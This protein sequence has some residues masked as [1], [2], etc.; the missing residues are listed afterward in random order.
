MAAIGVLI[1]L[2]ERERSGEGQL[3]DCS[4]FD[5][6]LSWLALVAA[7]TLA[8]RPRARRGELRLA[9]GLVCYRPYRVRRRVRH[10]GRAR[11]E[12]LGARS[13][14][15][16]GREDLIDHAFDPPGSDAHRAVCEIFAGRTR[17][18]WRAFASEHDCCL[19]PVLSLD[20]ALD[21]RARRGARDGR[22]A[23]P[24]GRR[25]AGQ[26][27]RGADQAEPYARGPAARA[28][29][30]ARMNFGELFLRKRITALDANPRYTRLWPFFDGDL[31]GQQRRII[32]VVG[33]EFAIDFG[34]PVTARPIE[35]LD[36]THILFEQHLAV[37][38]VTEQAPGRL[39][40]HAGANQVVGKISIAGNANGGELVA[41]Q[42]TV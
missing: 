13:A 30:W 21:S 41:L 14:A 28:R 10:A 24:A 9:G 35:I 15:G 42:I 5:G 38:P 31:N 16:V 7:E 12:V 1:A 19:E 3:V 23:A 37:T 34:L 26:V 6:A 32:L 27:A 8:E 11:A 20:E 2:R 40:L 25:A 18:E 22:R 29:A 4:M 33:N 17:E 36:T 39:V